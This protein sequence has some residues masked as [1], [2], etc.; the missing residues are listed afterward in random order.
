VSRVFVDS[1]VWID[2]LR[3][4][5][6]PETG[7][8]G[9]LFDALD[10]DGGA[11]HPIDILVGDIVLLEV[12]RG[13]DNDGQ[14]NRTRTILLAFEQVEIGGTQ[15]A[16]V[17]VDHFRTL[18]RHGFTVRKAVGCLI[19]AWCIGNDVPLLHRDRDFEPFVAHCGLKAFPGAQREG[20][21][22]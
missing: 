11:D 2:Y 7:Q 14:W 16:L 3:G 5:A 19:A 22:A 13:I 6:T 20:R 21:R 10:P 12:L 15:T 8:L 17:A 18:R 9:E 1:S 4:V